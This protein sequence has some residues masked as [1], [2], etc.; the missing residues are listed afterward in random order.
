MNRHPNYKFLVSD[1]TAESIDRT[2]RLAVPETHG[3]WEVRKNED[4]DG[5][6]AIY[7]TTQRNILI[8]VE[9]SDEYSDFGMVPGLDVYGMFPWETDDEK[10][11][12]K[13]FNFKE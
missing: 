7:V 2:L 3:T 11:I 12:K 5:F 6:F 13:Y 8:R 9:F 1:M 4:G 10:N